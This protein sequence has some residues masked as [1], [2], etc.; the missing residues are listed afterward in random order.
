MLKYLIIGMRKIF[1]LMDEALLSLSPVCRGKLAK[2][3]HNSWTTLYIWII[4]CIL[5]NHCQATDVQNGD[6][7]AGR[8]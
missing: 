2:N 4:V 8:N 3:A 1:S 6:D 7:A 5:F